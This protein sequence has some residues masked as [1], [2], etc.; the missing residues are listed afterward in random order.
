[1]ALATT[2]SL[3]GATSRLM[4]ATDQFSGTLLAVA[5]SAWNVV[6]SFLYGGRMAMAHFAGNLEEILLLLSR[7]ASFS[8]F[9]YGLTWLVG[10]TIAFF[11]CGVPCLLIALTRFASAGNSSIAF[12]SVCFVAL[13]CCLFLDTSKPRWESPDPCAHHVYGTDDFYICRGKYG[14][15]RL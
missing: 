13:G 9:L 1:M 5:V 2:D 11:I 10:K 6:L 12:L 8:F 7:A 15:F 14:G 4:K 3:D